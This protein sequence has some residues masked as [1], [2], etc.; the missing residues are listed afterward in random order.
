MLGTGACENG[1]VVLPCEL[2]RPLPSFGIPI[3]IGGMYGGNTGSETVP[4]LGI[5]GIVGAE[6]SGL[7]VESDELDSVSVSSDV[8]TVEEDPVDELTETLELQSD[9]E[10]EIEGHSQLRSVPRDELE[11]DELV[12]PD[13][14]V[15][16]EPEEVVVPELELPVDPE[17]LSVLPE[18][19]VVSVSV[20]LELSEVV[21]DEPDSFDLERSAT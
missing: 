12:E 4:I 2:N 21:V 18:D 8:D 16:S 20:V 1:G 9:L 15:D 14:V 13:S 19:E 5:N 10:A 7:G 6:I 3:P 17:E 11:P